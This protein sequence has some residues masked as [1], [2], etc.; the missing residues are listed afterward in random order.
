MRTYSLYEIHCKNN[1]RI[2]KSRRKEYIVI[3][4]A[5]EGYILVELECNSERGNKEVIIIT[6]EKYPKLERKLILILLG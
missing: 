2:I 4:V 3:V 1:A 5:L 6:K